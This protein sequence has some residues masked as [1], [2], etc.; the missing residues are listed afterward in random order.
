MN[1]QIDLKPCPFC[2]ETPYYYQYGIEWCVECR[3]SKCW[4]IP[5]TGLCSSREEAAN[6]WN[7]RADDE[8]A[9]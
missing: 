9:D 2:G 1:K 8:Q 3:S 5:E 7:R 6:K 4:I